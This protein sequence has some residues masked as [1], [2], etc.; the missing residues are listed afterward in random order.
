MWREYRGSKPK[1]HAMTALPII[2]SSNIA[3]NAPARTGCLEAFDAKTDDL[4]TWVGAVYETRRDGI[5]RFLL[6]QGL[7][8]TVAQEVTQDVFVDLFIALEK[9]MRI[10]SERA[11]LYAVAGR[12]AVDYWRG[13]RRQMRVDFDSEPTATANVPSSEPNPEAQLGC[14]ERL[15]RVAAGLR[16][17]TKEQRLCVQ[18]RAQGLRYR[19]IAKVLRVSTSTAAEWLDAAIDRLRE[20]AN[21][22]SLLARTVT[23]DLDG[24]RSKPAARMTPESQGFR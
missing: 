13:E 10:Q 8:P 20:Q 4:R 24:E 2:L 17:L 5:Y 14:K 7:N 12:A 15:A 18:L 9:G 1:Q 19:Q 23:A 22:K 3:N 16:S 11:W 21:G 6:G